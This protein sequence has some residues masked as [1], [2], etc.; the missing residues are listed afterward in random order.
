ME[1]LDLLVAD[2]ADV[3]DRSPWPVTEETLASALV[4]NPTYA[5]WRYADLRGHALAW[6]SDEAGLGRLVES[7]CAVQGRVWSRPDAAGERCVA[8]GS[9][10]S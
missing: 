4:A 7:E 1:D 5:G 10:G 2:M 9:G 6:L 8:P 3:V